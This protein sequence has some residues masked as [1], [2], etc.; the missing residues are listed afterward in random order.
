MRFNDALLGTVAVTSRSIGP[1]C[2]A[3][4][5]A[6]WL[7]GQLGGIEADVALWPVPIVFGIVGI[8]HELGH[9]VAVHALDG[10][11]EG[12]HGDRFR[13]AVDHR[14]IGPWPD[15]LVVVA[16]PS[17]ACAAGLIA[18]VLALVGMIPIH[19]GIAALFI[20]LGHLAAMIVPVGDGLEL[21]ERM[22]VIAKR[23]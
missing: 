13:V 15:L 14:S 16:G 11:V 22:A 9:V 5:I 18:A 3:T 21:R 1:A 7:L 10:A 20:G 12:V 2:A 23:R 17:F 4:A 8:V 19:L 6:L